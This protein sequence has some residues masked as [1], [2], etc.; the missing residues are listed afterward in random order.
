M[1]TAQQQQTSLNE[2]AHLAIESDHL[3]ALTMLEDS[4]ESGLGAV[5]AC[6]D[7]PALLVHVASKQLHGL[8]LLPAD[9]WVVVH[10]DGDL[11]QAAVELVDDLGDGGEGV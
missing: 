4:F 9:L 6:L 3:A 1:S 5:H 2:G 11:A 10:L 7:F 8:V